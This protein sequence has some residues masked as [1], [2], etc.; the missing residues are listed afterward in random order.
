MRKKHVNRQDR[1]SLGEYLLFMRGIRIPGKYQVLIILYFLASLAMIPV[2]IMLNTF[3][4]EM[5]DAQGNVPSA[6]LATYVVGYVLFGVL[7]AVSEIFLGIVSEQIN[8]ILRNNM[9][10]KLIHIKQACYAADHGEALVSRITTDCDYA[11][12]L[13]TTA[14]EFFATVV[15]SAGFWV[16]MFALNKKL[17]ACMLILVP[18]SLLI[19]WGY[20]KLMYQT[21]H[22]RQ[23]A[24]S[25]TT[26]YLIERAREL[27]FVKTSNLQEE[28]MRRGK[29]L[30]DIQ[31]RM[32]LQTG[33]LNT[34]FVALQSI[35]H[36]I[37]IVIPFAAGAELVR[38]GLMTP[39][40]VVAFYA[41]SGRG[42]MFLTQLIGY[43]GRVKQANGALTRVIR[44]M[45]LPEEDTRQGRELDIPDADIRFE[46]VVFGYEEGKDVLRGI[47]CTIKK[48]KVTALVGPNGSGKTT[49][50]K[51]IERLYEPKQ[52]RICF[53]ETDITEFS[54]HSW[55]KAFGV[56]SQGSPLM[57]GSIRDNMCYGCEREVTEEEFKVA[58]R[59]SHVEDFIGTL[60]YGYDT[61]LTS[62]GENLSGGQRQCI[63]IARAMMCSPDYLLLD[64]ATASLDMKQESAVIDALSE[65]MK[66]RTTI[67]IS[68]TP[69]VIREADYVIV[70]RD[71]RVERENDK[72][73]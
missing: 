33:F 20:T 56:V 31:Y 62:G 30:F 2:G 42:A 69:A 9:W 68:H 32:Q 37:S 21:A 70:L 46:N 28:E 72:A 66:N 39:G 18:V 1:V 71:G 52:G 26:A 48:N 6:Q 53:G 35:F 23:E 40:S 15:T 27:A 47:T 7:T 45:E 14:M 58:A 5:V 29:E 67:I 13:Y 64:E 61:V 63:A 19:G 51:L 50:L 36:I 16:S 54:L 3:S 55:R 17:S 41:V 22:K 25:D 60:P 38:Q 11:S 8:L 34:F 65:L 59:L 4:A 10:K 57:E 49:M 44:S 12:K 73:Q 24:L 43:S